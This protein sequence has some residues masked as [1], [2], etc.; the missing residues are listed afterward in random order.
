MRTTHSILMF[1][2]GG[3]IGMMKDPESDALKPLDFDHIHKEI[4][5]LKKFDYHLVWKSLDPILD[6]SN[7]Q[8]DN[9][10]QIARTIFDHYSDFD[11][12]V[13]LHGTD[14]L[15]YSA[16]AMSFMLQGLQ[17]PIIF[18]GSQLPIGLI[19][20]D[21]RENLISAIEM[22]G[23]RDGWKP[24]VPGVSIY[25]ENQLFQANRTTKYSAE[26]FNA[27]I[28]PN[29]PVLAESGVHLKFHKK[30]IN[31][32]PANTELKMYD[33]LGGNV[34]LLKL[35]PGIPESQVSSLFQGSGL[36]GIV[37]ETYGSGNAP[38]QAWFLENISSF[39]QKGGVI[40]NVTQC[41][42]GMVDQG[43]YETS[44]SLKE[45]GVI[46]GADITTE[47]A[48]TKMMHLLGQDYDHERLIFFLNTSIS[49]E[50]N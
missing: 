7:I 34:G 37:M 10:V 27:F 12:F 15:A 39:V 33:R 3:T 21:G 16:S 50:F 47:A 8:P 30:A 20:T 44:L 14:T 1:Y 25:F 41:L 11:A 18:T 31:R 4:P 38:M 45:A 22:A 26:D 5:E 24:M 6:S 36:K 9:W 17:K 42:A 48:I 43:R 13:I 29:Y 49:G 28:S 2:T 40:L 23:A 32:P 19:R 46:G 35:F